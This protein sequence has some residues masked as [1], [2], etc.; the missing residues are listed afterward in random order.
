MFKES[1][2]FFRI[3]LT[4]ISNKLTDTKPNYAEPGMIVSEYISFYESSTKE[5]LIELESLLEENKKLEIGNKFNIFEE[6]IRR[7]GRILDES[8]IKIKGLEEK[9]GIIESDLEKSKKRFQ[10]MKVNAKQRLII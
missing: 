6:Y 2:N 1:I 4:S 5:T 3:I 8:L 10:R 9:L 7:K